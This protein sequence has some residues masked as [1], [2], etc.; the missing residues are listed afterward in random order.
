MVYCLNWIP[1]YPYYFVQFVY[2]KIPMIAFYFLI[3]YK[4][5]RRGLGV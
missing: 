3:T 5:P 1:G 4:H 2:K